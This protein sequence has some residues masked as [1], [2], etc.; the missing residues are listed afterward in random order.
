MIKTDEIEIA[1]KEEVLWLKVKES[2]EARLKNAQ[3]SV[4]IET[5]VIEM[6]DKK[7]HDI[8]AKAGGK[9]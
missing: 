6:A 3:E 8:N 7:I 4:I 2:S 9:E 1:T 5:A